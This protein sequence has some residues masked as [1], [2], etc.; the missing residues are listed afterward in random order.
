[1]ACAAN[2][3]NDR[4]HRHEQQHDECHQAPNYLA[5]LVIGRRSDHGLTFLLLLLLLLRLALTLAHLVHCVL[6]ACPVFLFFSFGSK[7]KRGH[8]FRLHKD[9]GLDDIV[10]VRST[11]A[12]SGSGRSSR[13]DLILESG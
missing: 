9:H 3:A 6:L 2:S 7:P 10:V 5:S 12:T 4:R 11:V 1:M 8:G 13:V